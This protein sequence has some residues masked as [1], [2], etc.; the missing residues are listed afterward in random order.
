MTSGIIPEPVTLDLS[1]CEFLLNFLP[2]KGLE[3]AKGELEGGQM[4]SSKGSC[5]C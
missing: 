3:A 5:S 2:G 1:R 4:E